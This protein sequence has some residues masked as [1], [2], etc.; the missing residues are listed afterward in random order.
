MCGVDEALGDIQIPIMIDANFR[1]NEGWVTV[2]NRT[3]TDLDLS[4]HSNSSLF[5]SFLNHVTDL[6]HRAMTTLRGKYVIRRAKDICMSI[7]YTEGIAYDWKAWEIID[8][9][10]DIDH[11][12]RI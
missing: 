4:C 6:A 2:A 7:L 9:V 8:I 12:L 5:D 3:S 10:T 1:H 11:I